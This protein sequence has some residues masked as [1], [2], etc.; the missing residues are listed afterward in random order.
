MHE[1][2]R[3]AVRFRQDVCCLRF[4]P[5]FLLAFLALSVSITST[6]DSAA[7][8]S[9]EKGTDASLTVATSRATDG[10][11]QQAPRTAA[12]AE[13]P[14]DAERIATL[15]RTIES[16]EKRLKE[17]EAELNGPD[18]EYAQ[19]Q[20]EFQKLDADL[21]ELRE[22]LMEH[23]RDGKAQEA[24][25]L[26]KEITAIDKQWKLAKD[27][28][29]LAI[30]QR[31][32]VREEIATL[33][34]KLQK[35]R[36][37][38]DE[39]TGAKEP[40]EQAAASPTKPS[41]PNAHD[42]D[43]PKKSDA[44]GSG[45]QDEKSGAGMGPEESGEPPD[46]ELMNAE[47]EAKQKEEEAE[48]AQEEA[49][50]IGSRIADLQ[51]IIGQEQ[52][53]LGLARKKAD[54]ALATQQASEEE[55]TKKRADGASLDELGE[56]Q[57]RIAE[58]KARFIHSR[59]EVTDSSDRLNDAR[60]ELEDLRQQQILAMQEADQKRSEAEAA[61]GQVEEL[62]NPFTP[63]NLLK[64]AI[65]HGPRV[66]L[67]VIAM[68]VL[69]Q[70]TK[71]FSHRIIRLMV[72]GGNRGTTGERENRAT[73]L[74]GVFQ[75]AASVAVVIGG[76]LTVLDEMG[77]KIGVLMGGVAV[78]GLAVAFGAQNRMKDYFYGFVMLRENQYM[79]HDVVK[80]GEFSGQVERITLRMT[81][82]RDG[83]GV[84]HF[85]PNGQI[86]CLSNETHGWSRASFEIGVAYKENVDTVMSL[87]SELARGLRAD[88]T[89]SPMILEDPTAPGIESLG[90]SAVMIK[91][92]IKTRPHQHG[93]VKR[94][95]LRRIK[96][97]FDE[98]GIEIPFPHRTV[99]YR[100]ET[101]GATAESVAGL[102]KCA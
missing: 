50:A 5:A 73:T 81:V 37:A 66:L 41:K 99:Y 35:D 67:Y 71:I 53:V 70:A 76:T 26:G 47:A 75:N 83:N 25:A 19:A 17:L 100:H 30:E 56:L 64:W 54:L 72:T 16:E 69:L 44:A 28:F 49:Q 21:S 51:K 95:L 94:E 82:L 65:E 42:D 29:E 60:A 78:F 36:E 90:D 33:K 22:R 87:L 43:P 102:K 2:T 62:R 9:V 84:V 11:E 14:S 74:V 89:F 10:L 88:R 98:L 46:E 23:Q 101:D 93:A 3:I 40:Q 12:V 1:C 92:H 20:H 45:D 79:I 85:I 80:I 13:Q 7:Q 77:A 86:N 63:R 8:S 57:E 68:V 31:K 38:F 52:R 34:M 91:F 6:C 39:L 15:Q 18:G 59:A 4:H 55:L 48:E 58:A 24:A 61:K 97:R 96:N 32:T 27:R